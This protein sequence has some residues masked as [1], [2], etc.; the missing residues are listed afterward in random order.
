[1]N[2]FTENNERTK[3]QK[4]II[5][6]RMICSII[7]LVFCFIMIIIYIALC[8]QVR[9]NKKRSSQSIVPSER[10]E[11][12]NDFNA[13]APRKIGIGSHFMFFLI[14]SNFCGGILP[15]I[16][17]AI[18]YNNSVKQDKGCTALGFLHNIFDLYAVCWTSNI[19]K[20]FKASTQVTEFLPGEEK[21]RFL[22]GLLYS[23]ICSFLF[24]VIPFAGEDP[25]GDAETHCSFNYSQDNYPYNYI[26]NIIFT[27]VVFANLCY[28]VYGLFVVQ[29]Y[30]SKKLKLLK[31]SSPEYSVIKIY[32]SVFRIFPIVL[33][34]SRVLKGLSRTIEMILNIASK[35]SE[36]AKNNLAVTIFSFAGSIFFCLN[37][38]FNSL[39]CFY[40]FRGV[41]TR[42]TPNQGTES[43]I[44]NFRESDQVL[45]P[46][47]HT[48][49][50]HEP[51]EEDEVGD[52]S[53][54][55]ED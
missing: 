55:I 47:Q 37:G 41:F 13:T 33:V 12:D 29:R 45:I 42:D 21:K 48:H 36:Q 28:N 10:S 5:I 7:S 34:I 30:Y 52:S 8:F 26:W 31:N 27:V 1:M 51:E 50:D 11:C 16:F 18:Y 53:Y 39:I 25:Y 14:L 9:R 6:A 22:F 17:Y 35:E 44:P 4:Q 20:L 23:T 49:N 19:V 2:S 38:F 40:F 15:I 54:A 24:T 32:V 3:T 43:E 46:Q